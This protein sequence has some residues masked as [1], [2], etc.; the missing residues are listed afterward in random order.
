M[1]NSIEQTTGLLNTTFVGPSSRYVNSDLV[2][3]NSDN[4]KY[5]TFK[6]FKR[7]QQQSSPNDRFYVIS[8]GV[9]YR[10]DVVAKKIYGRESFWWILL[11]AN[12]MSDIMEFS[13]GKTITIPSPFQ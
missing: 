4:R 11:L 10:P 12:N 2:Y 6:T 13:A 9:A 3:Y 1:A 5:L 8:A 7:P